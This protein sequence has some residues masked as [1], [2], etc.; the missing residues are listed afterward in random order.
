[1]V[2]RL[3]VIKCDEDGKEIFRW[4]GVEISRTE[5]EV[6]LEAKFNMDRHRVG[7][8]E[9]HRGDRL[10]ETY[11]NRHWYN[12]YEVRDGATD[13]LKG[14]YCN[15]SFPAELGEREIL[16]RD[17]ALDLIVHPDGR[18][19]RVDEDE[20]DELQINGEVRGEALKGWEELQEGFRKRFAK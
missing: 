14:W 2:K 5:V 11:S 17:L 10:I 3:I 13:E 7:T 15:V 8:M 9:L 12:I 19:E 16:F 6:V 20:F 4:E 18:Q 1:M